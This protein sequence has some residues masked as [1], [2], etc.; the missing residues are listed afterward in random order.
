MLE[1]FCVQYCNLLFIA[2]GERRHQEYGCVLGA[3]EHQ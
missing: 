2:V 1:V 3:A